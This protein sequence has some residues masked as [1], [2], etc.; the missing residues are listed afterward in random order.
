M[1]SDTSGGS[2]AGGWEV[3]SVGESRAGGLC[4]L[5]FLCGL[6]GHIPEHSMSFVPELL[7]ANS[8]N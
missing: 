5:V 4:L 2:R 8:M 3:G 6:P 7:N 1:A